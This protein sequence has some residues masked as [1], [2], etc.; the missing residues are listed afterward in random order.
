MG[1]KRKSLIK[2]SEKFHMSIH[3]LWGVI[4]ALTIKKFLADISLFLLLTV[5]VLGSL[6]PD[7]D[8]VLYIF[9]YGRKS[10]YSRFIR[11]FISQKQLKK[12]FWFCKNNHKLNTGLY[13]HNILTM[14]VI[15]MLSINSIISKNYLLAT[16]FL[17]WSI[18]YLYDIFE[19]LLFFGKINKNWFLKFDKKIINKDLL[20]F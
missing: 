20:R 5:G 16:F 17:A 2:L 8:H 7:F 13:S 1:K 11:Q 3:I 9:I 10:E 12:T 14:I 19:D 15:L 4:I 18:H 6:L